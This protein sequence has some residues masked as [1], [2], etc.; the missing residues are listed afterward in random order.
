MKVGRVVVWVDCVCGND[1]EFPDAEPDGITYESIPCDDCGRRIE[2]LVDVE[3]R[4]C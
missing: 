4:E 2:I 1:V 3:A